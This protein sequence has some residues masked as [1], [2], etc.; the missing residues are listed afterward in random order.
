MHSAFLSLL[1]RINYCLMLYCRPPFARETS[2]PW[3][4]AKLPTS[5][6]RKKRKGAKESFIIISFA[7]QK[8]IKNLEIFLHASY[9]IRRIL[10]IYC[11]QAWKNS[12]SFSASF[13]QDWHTKT[14]RYPPLKKESTKFI[15]KIKP[16]PIQVQQRKP[17]AALLKNTV[18]FLNQPTLLNKICITVISFP[19]RALTHPLPSYQNNLALDYLW[20]WDFLSLCLNNEYNYWQF[21]AVMVPENALEPQ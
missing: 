14:T 4:T 6:I 3:N 2:T 1:T 13:L 11:I 17:T 10:V 8:D 20:W 18:L 16:K 5:Q 12:V 15:L 9:D 7:K 19:L 21:C